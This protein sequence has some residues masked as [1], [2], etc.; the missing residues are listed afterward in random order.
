MSVRPYGFGLELV[1]V[2]VSVF[3]SVFAG[4][5]MVFVSL[6]FSVLTAGFTIVVLDSFF[7]AGAAGATSVLCSH[8]PKSA[9][10]ARMQ[11]SFFIIWIDCPYWD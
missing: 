6:V 9:A 1:V 10:L 4:A 8:A 11:I 3:F 2:V 7:S 5:T